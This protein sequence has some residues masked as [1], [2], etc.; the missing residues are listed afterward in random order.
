MFLTQTVSKLL[1]E[2]GEYI[3]LYKIIESV[4]YKMR[5]IFVTSFVFVFILTHP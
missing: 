2:V 5:H 4:E 3:Y 1:W